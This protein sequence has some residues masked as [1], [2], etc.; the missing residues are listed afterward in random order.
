MQIQAD[1]NSQ[2]Q[3]IIR[4]NPDFIAGLKQ[5]LATGVAAGDGMYSGDPAYYL[6]CGRSALDV[7][8]VAIER[9]GR[10]QEE[11]DAVLDFAC[12]FGRVTRWLI[13][14]FPAARVEGMDTNLKSVNAVRGLYGIP[15]H[16]IER[17]WGNV[18]EDQFDLIWVGSL[19]T[20]LSEEKSDHLLALMRRLLKPGGIL[21]ATTHGE[22]VVNRI[23][24]REKTYNLQEEAIEQILSQYRARQYG[25]SGYDYNPEYGI[26]IA[27]PAKI[28]E[29]ARRAQLQPLAFIDR[30]WVQHQD[31]HAFR[32]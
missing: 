32:R 28:I 20:H 25:F 15:V 6:R 23:E 22:Y 18:P 21:A 12:G 27:T 17:D 16:H 11:F 19:F 26:S 1:L 30:G 3:E 31:F 29:M 8:S 5:G 9:A 24:T 10:K 13:A 2:L 7:I 14:A 4:A